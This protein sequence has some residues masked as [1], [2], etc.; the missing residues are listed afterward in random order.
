MTFNDAPLTLD[1]DA[2]EV[3]KPPMLMT[4]RGIT[5]ILNGKSFTVAATHPNFSILKKAIIDENWAEVE[6]LASV[7]E[8]V[9]TY[10]KGNVS[11]RNGKVF[12]K[13]PY[14]KEEEECSGYIVD[15]IIQFMSEGLNPEPLLNFLQ[16]LMQNHSFRVIN[17]L[18]KFLSHKNMPIDPD[19]DFYGYKAIRR[20][21][22]DKRTGKIS[23]QIGC[24]LVF[25]RRHVD[26]NPQNDCSYGLHVGSIQYVK[27]F[28]GGYGNGGDRIIIVKVNPADV[29]AVPEYDVSKLRCCRYVVVSEYQGLLPD[30]TYEAGQ[31][32]TPDGVGNDEDI[33]DDWD[34]DYDYDTDYCDECG[35]EIDD[36]I[37]E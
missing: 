4:E 11:V 28:A 36:C 17:D 31:G 3:K 13:N 25:E 23:N 12:Y 5:L 15:K 29:V 35:E 2:P 30:T 19:G 7:E 24:E 8:A 26:D 16:K 33:D 1:D 10:V 18:Y 27:S 6:Q 22:T 14:S 20:D 37:C 21:W 9:K 34:D 32:V